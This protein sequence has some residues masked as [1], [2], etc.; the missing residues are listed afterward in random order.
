MDCI[1]FAVMMR[2]DTHAD[3]YRDRK[4]QPWPTFEVTNNV[5]FVTLQSYAGR[6]WRAGEEEQIKFFQHP[7]AKK[8][9]KV[10]QQTNTHLLLL[11]VPP[12]ICI[13][14]V[15]DQPIFNLQI[16]LFPTRSDK[17]QCKLGDM[18]LRR[19]HYHRAGTCT[20]REYPRS[21]LPRALRKHDY[22][23]YP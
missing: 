9:T 13:V 11:S 16:T 3:T 1:Q 21:L 22:T 15:H 12:D 2:A 10:P 8:G 7:A 18:C 17:K 23:L 20:K 5:V 14:L 19:S 6:G 4:I